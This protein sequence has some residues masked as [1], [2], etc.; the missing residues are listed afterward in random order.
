MRIAL[1]SRTTAIG[2]GASAVAEALTD[3]LRRLGEQADLITIHPHPPSTVAQPL[4]RWGWLAAAVRR[5]QLTSERAFGFVVPIETATLLRRLRGY[6]IVHFH[7]I[8]SAI[9][10]W[11]LVQT[12]R[13]LPTVLTLHDCSA[14]TGGCLYMLDCPGYRHLCGNCPAKQGSR[15]PLYRW[16][17]SRLSLALKRRMHLTSN[18]NLITP[19]AWMAARAAEAKVFRH[20][21]TVIPNGC[22]VDCFHPRRRDPARRR[23]GIA[24]TDR[25]VLLS[26]ASLDDPRKGIAD[27]I[28]A[29]REIARRDRGPW[30]LLMGRNTARVRAMIP[31]LRCLDL[32]YVTARSE[33][34]DAYAAADVFLFPSHADNL[35]LAVQESMAS[36]TPVVAYNIGGVPEMVDNG[37][38]GFLVPEGATDL[39]ATATAQLLFNRQLWSTFSTQSRKLARTRWDYS[40]CRERHLHTYKRLSGST[41]H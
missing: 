3:E 32:G 13:R 29:L 34:A 41:A 11:T 33:A 40:T 9:S 12:S 26:A 1:V 6:D 27:S 15:H 23:W 28:A 30:V 24:E 21:A 17:F 25:V 36:G 35:P 18:Y 4:F 7:D 20:P 2:G 31:E 19:S 38:S 5:I 8:W 16:D 10:P 37:H 39:L 14:F 22:D